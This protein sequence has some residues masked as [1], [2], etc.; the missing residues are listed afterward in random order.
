MFREINVR[1]VTKASR[2]NNDSQREYEDE[3][4]NE[5]KKEGFSSV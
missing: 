5:E 3:C 4:I 2:V 1:R